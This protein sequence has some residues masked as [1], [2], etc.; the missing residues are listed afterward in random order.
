VSLFDD[1]QDM[2]IPD[3]QLLSGQSVPSEPELTSFVAT[4]RDLADG[5]APTPSAALAALLRDG[6]PAAQPDSRADVADLGAHRSRRRTLRRAGAVA[7]TTVALKVALGVAVAAAAVVGASQLDGAPD[8]VREPAQAV[9][10]AVVDTWQ[11]V[12]GT[13]PAVEPVTPQQVPAVP[14][15]PQDGAPAVPAAPAAPCD[16]SCAVDPAPGRGP[17]VI[18]P[19]STTAPGQTGEA[20]GAPADPGRPA[21]PGKPTDPGRSD[22][23]PGQDRKATPAPAATPAQG[24]PAVRPTQAPAHGG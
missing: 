9:V 5:P 12:T 24:A 1:D 15:D 21:E 8:I 13:A 23:A 2:R 22:E 19:G 17:V 14:S 11:A 16:G 10:G 7:G 4:L 20:P 18:P 6:L 3:E